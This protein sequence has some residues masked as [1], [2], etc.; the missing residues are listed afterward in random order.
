[1]RRRLGLNPWQ[2]IKAH[3]DGAEFLLWPRLRALFQEGFSEFLGSMILTLIYHG[4]LA[5]TTLGV[6]VQSAPGGKSYGSYQSL[7]WGVG[8]GVMLGIYVAGDS[9]SYLNPALTVSN[10]I[11]RGLPPRSVPILVI[12]QFLGCFVG[13]GL[14]YANYVSAIDWYAG[15]G[16]RTVP[17]TPMATAPIFAT[18]PSSFAPKAS[19]AFSII[20]PCAVINIVTSALK[21]DYNN[22]VSKAGGNF[23]PLAMFFL[24]YSI[25]IA[26]G[27]ETGGAVN[28]ALD[29]SGRLMSNALGYPNTVWSS[30]GYYFW[31]PLILP[32]SY[33]PTCLPLR[34]HLSAAATQHD[35]VIL[36]IPTSQHSQRRAVS[37]GPTLPPALWSLQN[38]TLY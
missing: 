25:A 17:P 29:F 5:Q 9:G 21:D 3:S 1:M 19:Q 36:L 33:L 4:T 38:T 8:T 13:A 27:W 31:M 34:H 15:V 7:P 2:P 10:A 37:L 20:I 28:P 16:V 32:R 30:G 22:G 35:G 6:S 14:V 18:Y 23:F 24:F 26:F 11:L 12:S